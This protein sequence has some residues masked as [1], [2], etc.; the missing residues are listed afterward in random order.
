MNIASCIS[1]ENVFCL[2]WTVHVTWCTFVFITCVGK[3]CVRNRY[4]NPLGWKWQRQ[5]K[6]TLK[7]IINTSNEMKA[8]TNKCH[9]FSVLLFDH[10]TFA[11]NC[12]FSWA[13]QNQV[14]TRGV[15]NRKKRLFSFF[16]SK[17]P[18]SLFLL[19]LKTLKKLKTPTF[20]LWLFC[21][22]KG[23]AGTRIHFFEIFLKFN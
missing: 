21:S 12:L 3:E 6:A 13:W 11:R 15:S 9:I 5:A 17:T 23:P 14:F 22:N 4:G 19:M 16:I 8:Q 2:F 20:F 7:N 10:A 1:I 18:H